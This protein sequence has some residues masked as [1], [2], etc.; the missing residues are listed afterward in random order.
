VPPDAFTLTAG[1]IV[2]IEITGIGIL[3]NVVEQQT[4]LEG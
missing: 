4:A 2:L 3:R 1:D